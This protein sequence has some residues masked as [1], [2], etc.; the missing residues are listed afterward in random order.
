MMQGNTYINFKI[1]I[2]L[3]SSIAKKG[4]LVNHTWKWLGKKKNREIAGWP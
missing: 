3:G 4:V 2:C 1:G